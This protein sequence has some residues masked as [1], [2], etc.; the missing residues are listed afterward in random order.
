MNRLCDKVAIVTGAASGIG[1]AT[2]RLFAAEGARVVATDIAAIDGDA[3]QA[4]MGP[5]VEFLAQD[6]RSEA[7]WTEVV[8]HVA[9]RYGKVDVLANVAGIN[10]V[11][12][13]E[14][15]TQDP[16]RL[17][18]ATWR[19]IHEVNAEGTMLGCRSV[20]A[21]MRAAGG[22]AIVNVSSIAAQKGW[23][24][25]GAYG[26]SKAA[27]LQW[28]KTVARFC[29]QNG[30]NIRCNAVLPGPVDTP[31]LLP[32]GRTAPLAGDGRAGVDHVPLRR[33]AAPEEIARPMLF[34]AS[35]EA[36]YVTGIGLLVDGGLSA[37]K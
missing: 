22:G 26:A 10:G 29:A 35:D 32:P 1:R 16:D 12:P 21:A 8:T 34:L 14:T 24:V 4:D 5:N 11:L 15:P 17:T 33:Y 28:T 9:G 19:W 25:R 27:I 6:V 13:A 30:W 7:R 20:I 18:L 36:S 3:W 23:P 37:A 31:M 2:A